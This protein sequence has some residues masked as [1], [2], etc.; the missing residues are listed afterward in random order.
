[1]H[2]ILTVLFSL[3]LQI[4]SDVSATDEIVYFLEGVG[5]DKY[6]LN[7]FTVGHKNGLIRVHQILDRELI[8]VYKASTKVQTIILL[9]YFVDHQEKITFY[10]SLTND[11]Q[12]V[13]RLKLPRRVKSTIKK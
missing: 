2:I 7:V 3:C 13:R 12:T 6:P 4:R 10:S 5:A 8:S 11:E 1:M 9:Q